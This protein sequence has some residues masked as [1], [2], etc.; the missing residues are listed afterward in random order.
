MKFP[1]FRD[2]N[3]LRAEKIY[4]TDR[5]IERFFLWI[6][7]PWITPNHITILRMVATPPTITLLFLQYYDY[8]I[9]CFLLVASTDAL[10]GALARTRNQITVWG[11]MFD[12]LADK[13]LIIPTLALL[14]F[15]NVSSILASA[16]I[17]IDVLIIILALLWRR[18]GET[19]QANLWGKLKM[20]CQVAGIVIL[21]FGLM[22]GQDGMLPLASFTLG[23]SIFFGLLSIMRHGV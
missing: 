17:A 10:D 9:P 1:S 8:G 20:I 13:L 5:F 22:L 15:A 21:L 23:T 11:M 6:I 2:T 14:I 3:Y 12:P 4:P 16:M 18:K 7:P 19:V